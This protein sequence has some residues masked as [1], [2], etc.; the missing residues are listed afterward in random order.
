VHDALDGLTVRESTTVKQTLVEP[1]AALD[2][3][4]S[5]EWTALFDEG[6]L[7]SIPSTG[8]LPG[9]EDVSPA[10]STPRA[11]TAPTATIPIDGMRWC[12]YTVEPPPADAPESGAATA[13]PGAITLHTGRF[14]A[15]GTLDMA[16]AR[17]VAGVAASDPVPR[18]CDASASMFLVLVPSRGEPDLG[19]TFTAELDGCELLYRDGSGSR[20]LPADVRDILI[21]QTAS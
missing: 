11:G 21:A 17:L 14:V 18:S 5:T 15:G 2:S 10:T 7:L 3:G 9:I 16:T 1:R 19:M 8:S 20:A 4:C 12:R 6:I 13:L